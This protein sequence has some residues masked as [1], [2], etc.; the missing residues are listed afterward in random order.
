[1]IM[2]RIIALLTSAASL[3]VGYYVYSHYFGASTPASQL[4]ASS[5]KDTVQN[6]LYK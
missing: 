1:M 6:Q 5:V 3:A 2:R 4:P